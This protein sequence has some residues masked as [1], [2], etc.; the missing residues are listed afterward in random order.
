MHVFPLPAYKKQMQG[1]FV[2]KKA[3]AAGFPRM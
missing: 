1:I 3:P 2:S